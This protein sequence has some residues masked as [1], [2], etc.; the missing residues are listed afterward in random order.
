MNNKPPIPKKLT[1]LDLEQK[2]YNNDTPNHWDEIHD[3]Y[4]QSIDIQR[5]YLQLYQTLD[6]DLKEFYKD[7]TEFNVTLSTFL[8]DL[9]EF[10]KIL[11]KIYTAHKDKSGIIL[12]GTDD[13]QLYYDIGIQY[14]VIFTTYTQQLQVAAAVLTY[15][16]NEY[17]NYLTNLTQDFNTTNE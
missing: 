2:N 14:Q 1:H 4:N 3:Y 11:N 6:D 16:V 13:M 17:S 12:S 7:N 10:D 8:K 9:L 15:Y 5:T